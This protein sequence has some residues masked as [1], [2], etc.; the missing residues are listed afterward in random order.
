MDNLLPVKQVI[1]L[2]FEERLGVY[3]AYERLH[4][5]TSYGKEHNCKFQTYS[6]IH[7]IDEVEKFLHSA[8]VAMKDFAD[9][10]RKHGYHCTGVTST[11]YSK[12]YKLGL[13]FPKDDTKPYWY[14]RQAWYRGKLMVPQQ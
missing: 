6:I 8:P 9:F 4:V 7:C 2:F 13:L 10:V 1:N 14:N 3:N 5:A 12:S 11:W